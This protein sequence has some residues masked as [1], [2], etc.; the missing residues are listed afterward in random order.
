M[1]F[2]VIHIKSKSEVLHG[3]RSIFLNPFTGREIRD[4]DTSCGD[5]DC[6]G[7][8]NPDWRDV[9]EDEYLFLP[10]TGL[11]DEWDKELFEDDVIQLSNGLVARIKYEPDHGGFI[12]QWKRS[13][14]NQHDVR[15][16]CD[17]ACEA[18]LLGN[19]NTDPH[20]KQML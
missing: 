14:P 9:H 8:P 15:L 16:T 7:G 13:G 2:K 3:Y 18:K 12:A 4:M 10:F 5:P 1:K 17:I 6:C 19:V 11:K 20:L